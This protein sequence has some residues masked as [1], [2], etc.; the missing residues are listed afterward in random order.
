MFSYKNVFWHAICE[1]SC[2]AYGLEASDINS[3]GG[4]PYVLLLERSEQPCRFSSSYWVMACL[5]VV[6]A[7]AVVAVTEFTWSYCCRETLYAYVLNSRCRS[8]GDTWVS[9]LRSALC[10]LQNVTFCSGISVKSVDCRWV[11][12]IYNLPWVV[13]VIWDQCG[14]VR[15]FRLQW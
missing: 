6:F 3:F 8:P 5:C 14:V 1:D 7:Y 15:S 12:A 13:W 2:T 4:L 10:P 11:F 9:A